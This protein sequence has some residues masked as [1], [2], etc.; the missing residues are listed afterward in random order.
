[1]VSAKIHQIVQGYYSHDI[2]VNYFQSNKVVIKS[3]FAFAHAV[4]SGT[5]KHF[6]LLLAATRGKVTWVTNGFRVT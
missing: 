1:M 6:P 3:V 2:H 5:R 4:V